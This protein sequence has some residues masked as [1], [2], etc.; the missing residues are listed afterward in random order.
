YKMTDSLVTDPATGSTTGLMNIE[1][2]SWDEGIIRRAGL[3]KNILPRLLYPNEVAGKVT[4]EASKEIGFLEGTPVLCGCG[5]AGATTM[6]AGAIREGD[7]YIYLGTTGWVAFPSTPSKLERTNVFTLTH[8]PKDLYISIVPLLNVGNVHQWAIDSF[9][10]YPVENK[11]EEFEKLVKRTE[12]GAGGVLCLPYLQG[13]RGHIQDHEARGAFW[14][15]HSQTKKEHLLR[16]VIEGLC[17]SMRQAL[18]VLMPQKNGSLTIIGGGTKSRVWCQCLADV[19]GRTI[20]VTKD[21]EYL[22]AI[23]AAAPAFIY[24]GWAESYEEFADRY[25]KDGE[26]TKEYKPIEEHVYLYQNLYEKFNKLY[27][28]LRNVYNDEN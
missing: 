26:N 1:S 3:D 22:P 4:K 10:D 5:D 7:S 20:A 9:I 15:I 13:E 28:N 12:P 6:G 25:V 11:Y 21:S 19:L 27:P 2:R 23:G 16:A 18:E 14:G 24:L 17:L 8:L